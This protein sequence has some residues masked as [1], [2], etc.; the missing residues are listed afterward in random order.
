MPFTRTKTISHHASPPS[1][2]IPKTHSVYKKTHSPLC[3]QALKA[4]APRRRLLSSKN[5][6]NARALASKKSLFSPATAANTSRVETT[7]LPIETAPHFEGA[8]VEAARL[9]KDGQLVALPTETVYGLAA[10]A[11]D[12]NAV[13]AIYKVKGRPAHNPI[14]VHVSSLAMARRCVAAWPEAAE[15]LAQRFWPGPLT[16]V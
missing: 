16:F 13:A 6:G 14:I 9:L 1:F 2:L 11:F 8:A 12:A 15:K 4:P 5:P 7:V 3:L 10:N